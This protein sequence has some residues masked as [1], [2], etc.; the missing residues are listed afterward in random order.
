MQNDI[1]NKL[2]EIIYKLELFKIKNV[3]I[4]VSHIFTAVVSI[5][6]S[7]LISKLI[8]QF[9]KQRVFKRMEIDSG[10]EFTLLR[11]THY[12]LLAVGLY[13]G[14]ATINIPMGAILG[15]FAVLGV[16]IGFGLQNLTSNFVSGVILL[17]ERPVKIND[18]IE[19]DD[20]WGDIEKINLRTTVVRTPDNI[21]IIVPN[22]K[23]LE[24]NLINYSYGDT[25]IRLNI[26]VGVAYGSPVNKVIEI[27]KGIAE[28]HKEILKDPAPK[29]WFSE[30]GASS[31]N[32]E[33]LVWIENPSRKYWIISDVNKEIDNHFRKNN[34]EIP[35]PQQDIYV[36]KIVSSEKA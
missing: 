8:R 14:L 3:S 18:R 23:L 30:F 29:V 31:L 22:S 34:I 27:V 1:W 24:N 4:T 32:F 9:L 6:I 33:L 25:K 7:M 20:V 13:I 28:K 15:L 36:R 21:R 10:I 26:P 35:F 17:L 19:I 5:L 12:L 16:G 11:I 2:H